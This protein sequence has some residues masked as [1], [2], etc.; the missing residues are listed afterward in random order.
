MSNAFS[1]EIPLESFKDK[2]T[3]YSFEK[4]ISGTN[5]LSGALERNI[6]ELAFLNKKSNGI[7][8]IHNEENSN[9]SECSELLLALRNYRIKNNLGDNIFDKDLLA[10]KKKITKR[11]NN[12]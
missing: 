9:I 8:L 10:A 1:N 12:L 11:L 5:G 4:A 3:V 2:F 6:N 7:K